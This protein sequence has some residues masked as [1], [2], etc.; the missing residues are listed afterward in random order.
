MNQTCMEEPKSITMGSAR[1]ELD[2]E[3]TFGKTE[4]EIGRCSK[5]GCGNF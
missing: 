3:K 2:K 4:N 5:E 1:I